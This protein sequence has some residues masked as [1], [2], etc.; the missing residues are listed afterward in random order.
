MF[1]M[2]FHIEEIGGEPY[3]LPNSFQVS[4]RIKTASTVMGKFGL[5]SNLEYL[6]LGTVILIAVTLMNICEV[7]NN[8]GDYIQAC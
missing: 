2:G 3:Q 8:S 1:P 7:D 4:I 5:S 6:S